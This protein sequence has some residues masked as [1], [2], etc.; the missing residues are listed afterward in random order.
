MGAAPWPWHRTGDP[1]PVAGCVAGR[2]WL[3]VSRAAPAGR[4]RLAGGG[5]E[6]VGSQPPPPPLQAHVQGPAAT[7]RRTI[8]VETTGA[9]GGPHHEAR[10]KVN[11]CGVS[12]GNSLSSLQSYT[13]AS[14][15]CLQVPER[16]NARRGGTRRRVLTQVC[17]RI[18][19]LAIEYLEL[20]PVSFD[21]TVT[22]ARPEPHCSRCQAWWSTVCC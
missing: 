10:Q 22:L 17:F 8:Q 2:A 14:S 15:R 18:G 1:H 5:M 13:A 19:W 3:P 7:D 6:D 9:R 12:S 21:D 4:P 16:G 20:L 11:P